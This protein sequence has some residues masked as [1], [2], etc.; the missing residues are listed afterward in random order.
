MGSMRGLVVVLFIRLRDLPCWSWND[1]PRENVRLSDAGDKREEPVGVLWRMKR[2]RDEG[3]GE[4]FNMGALWRIS[5]G[6][7]AHRDSSGWRRD[8]VIA[9]VILLYTHLEGAG[10]ELISFLLTEGVNKNTA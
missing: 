1:R 7:E 2:D 4:D 6:Y 9:V 3:R 10:A 5:A 8:M